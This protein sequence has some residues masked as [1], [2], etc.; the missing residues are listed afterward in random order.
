VGLTHLG[1]AEPTR[2]RVCDQPSPLTR[3]DW[4]QSFT[5]QRNSPS[6]TRPTLC[7]ENDLEISFHPRLQGGQITSELFNI[8]RKYYMP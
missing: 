2:P 5:L 7:H 3:T 1:L 8:I 6:P 4:S